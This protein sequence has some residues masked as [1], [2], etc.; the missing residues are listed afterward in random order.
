MSTTVLIQFENKNWHAGGV[1]II[2]DELFDHPIMQDALDQISK[3][4]RYEFVTSRERPVDFD[5]LYNF[6]DQLS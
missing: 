6:I 4:W 3:S 1:A 5:A 2:P